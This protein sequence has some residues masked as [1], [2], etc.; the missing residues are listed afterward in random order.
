MDQLPLGILYTGNRVDGYKADEIVQELGI[1]KVADLICP[2]PAEFQKLVTK[3]WS[4][5]KE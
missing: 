1:T 4:K 2:N 5:T 3:D